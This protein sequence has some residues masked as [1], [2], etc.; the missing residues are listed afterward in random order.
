MPPGITRLQ[1]APAA[2]DAAAVVFDQLLQR[3][4]DIASSTTH[5]LFT[6]PEPANS[7]V[8]VDL[9]GRPKLGEPVRAAAQDGAD[10]RDGLDV[11]DGGRAAVDAGAGRERRLQA[12]LALLALEALHQG[13]LVAADVGPAAVCVDVDVV[14][15]AVDVALADQL[16]R[17]RPA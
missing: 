8:P 1:V 3:D 5:G 4:A 9:F 11:V 14:V 10:D 13:G 6:W 2:A 17:R 7:L 15:P 12:R 16:G